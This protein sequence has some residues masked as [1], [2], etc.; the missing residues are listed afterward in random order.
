MVRPRHPR[1]PGSPGLLLRPLQ[2]DDEEAATAADAELRVEGFPFLLEREL[3]GSFADYLELLERRR[4]GDVRDGWVRSTFLV[5]DVGGV[6]VG[7]AS[8]RHELNDFLRREGGHVGYAVRPAFRGHGHA[9]AILRGALA[10]L[11][12]TGVERALVT[13]EQDNVASIG[14]IRACGGEL[15]GVVATDHGPVRRHWVPTAASVA[16]G[17]VPMAAD[18]GTG[19]AVVGGDPSVGAVGRSRGRRPRR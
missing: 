18:D 4:R 14:V 19:R 17:V 16:D 9:T 13:C 12:A 2:A 11:A 5:G 10:V 1:R 3:C 6:V 7:R 15:D 8:I